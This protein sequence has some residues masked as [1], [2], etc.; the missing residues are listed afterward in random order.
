MDLAA[1]MGA[2]SWE[3]GLVR[4]MCRTAQEQLERQLRPGVRPE[5]CGEAFPVAAAWM[6]LSNLYAAGGAEQV[7]S[8]TAGSM[9]IRTGG[10][11]ART[12]AEQAGQLM[13]PF[14]RENTFAAM[15]VKG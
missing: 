12:L 2:E 3:E 13:A 5:D 9:T 8:F 6:A 10:N 14:C 7:E 11:G 4:S 15:G 1:A